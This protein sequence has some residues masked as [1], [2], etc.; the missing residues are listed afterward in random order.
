VVAICEGVR[1]AWVAS[2]VRPE[3]NCRRA[4]WRRLER[5]TAAAGR[6]DAERARL[7]VGPG[8]SF[9]RR[10]RRLEHRKGHDVL[11]DAVAMLPDLPL[12]V[13][14]AGA[15]TLA[16]TLAHATAPLVSGDRVRW[17]RPGGPTSPGFLAAADR[18]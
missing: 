14:C 5:F 12:R 9:A 8:E 17:L 6:R 13:F 2:G 4:E 7:D 18:W 11:L 15:G 3:R 16:A 10:R 1:G